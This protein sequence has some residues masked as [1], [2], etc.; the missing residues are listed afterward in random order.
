MDKREINI[1]K[2][3]QSIEKYEKMG[4]QHPYLKRETL[5]ERLELIRKEKEAKENNVEVCE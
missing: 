4:R 5:E 2:N 3:L 1:L